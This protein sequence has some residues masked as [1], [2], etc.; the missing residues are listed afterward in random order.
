M[1]AS[2]L[3]PL[4]A[5]TLASAQWSP[6][7][8]PTGI[9]IQ[10]A[11]IL[12]G[13]T[14]VGVDSTG[15]AWTTSDRGA[16]WNVLPEDSQGAGWGIEI[17]ADG[18]ALEWAEDG[19]YYH[20]YEASSLSWK[21]AV[22][23]RKVT[24]R[25]GLSESG[26]MWDN[27][28]SGYLHLWIEYPDSV[29]IFQSADTGRTWKTAAALAQSDIPGGI[30]D[31]WPSHTSFVGTR[32]WVADTIRRVLKSTLDGKS[33]REIPFPTGIVSEAIV[34][35]LP[36]GALVGAGRQQDGSVVWSSTTDSGKTWA[37]YDASLPGSIS[38]LGMDL[39]GGGTLDPSFD[40]DQEKDVYF[41]PTGSNFWTALPTGYAKGGDFF[42]DAGRLYN[43][44]PT[45]LVS[46]DIGA[47]NIRGRGNSSSVRSW[48]LQGSDLVISG[49]RASDWTLRD[50]SGRAFA[51]GSFNGSDLRIPL[52]H[53][54]GFMVVQMEGDETSH[55]PVF[56]PGNPDRR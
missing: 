41:R 2:F 24:T 46:V 18:L 10:D 44:G 27:V 50:L 26:D 3:A 42:A 6:V 55:F 21:P 32:L 31:A 45:G 48:S 30:G 37:P 7:R 40:G 28:F 11:T 35:S 1:I 22:F 52:G 38:S 49:T 8:Q 34:D 12:P 43:A 53:N 25:Q 5:T 23:D 47:V 54:R 13:G 4:L 20:R 15:S 14:W 36:S 9:V 17:M 16:N 39:P 29:L 19:S 56:V 51:S 33:W